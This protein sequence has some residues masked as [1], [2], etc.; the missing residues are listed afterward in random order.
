MPAPMKW[1]SFLTLTLATSA[2]AQAPFA[3]PASSTTTAYRNVRII[4]G[5]GAPVI[6][7]AFEEAVIILPGPGATPSRPAAYD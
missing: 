3:P 4:D 5:T 2:L 7:I 6:T 1:L